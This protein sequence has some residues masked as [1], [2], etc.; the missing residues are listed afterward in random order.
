MCAARQQS[1]RA[2]TAWGKWVR[3]QPKGVLTEAMRATGLSWSTV[4]HAQ[5]RRVRTEMAKA[6]SAFTKGAVAVAD[7][8]IPSKLP[9]LRVKS[10]KR[11]RSVRARRAA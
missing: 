10:R 2:E 3:R 4:S 9:L 6:L 1:E 8:E 11:R 5:W 7:I